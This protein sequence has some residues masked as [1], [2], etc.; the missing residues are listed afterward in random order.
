V[1]VAALAAAFIAAQAGQTQVS[2]ATSILRANAKSQAAFAALVDPALQN[3]AN[4][5]SG[6]G[7]SVDISA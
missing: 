3:G 6:V 7:N 2:I 1:D 4:L 5:P